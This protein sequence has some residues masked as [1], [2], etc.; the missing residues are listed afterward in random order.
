MSKQETL[1]SIHGLLFR[2][3]DALPTLVE[4]LHRTS[5]SLAALSTG[6]VLSSEE[7][8][9]LTGYSRQTS[10]TRQLEKWRIPY[11]MT[12]TGM[13]RVLR[14]DVSWDDS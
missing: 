1:E 6:I 13:V 7:L 10:Q 4:E 9:Q 12:G 5:E 11:Q 14:K 8:V 2:L 3:N